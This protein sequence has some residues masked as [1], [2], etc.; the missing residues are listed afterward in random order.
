MENLVSG[1]SSP[2]ELA[3]QVLASQLRLK[4]L[5]ELWRNAKATGD[6]EVAKDLLSQI[7]EQKKEIKKL[8]DMIGKVHKRRVTLSRRLFQKK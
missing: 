2:S 3:E 4:Q 5:K 7:Q 1:S 8:Q 6:Y